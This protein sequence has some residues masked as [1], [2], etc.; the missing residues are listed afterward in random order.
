MTDAKKSTNPGE[1][2]KG[3]CIAMGSETRPT[4]IV[5]KKTLITLTGVKLSSEYG[6]Q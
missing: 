5:G 6:S 1:E 4:I 2:R 3:L